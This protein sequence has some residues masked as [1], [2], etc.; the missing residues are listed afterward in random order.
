[1]EKINFEDLP[2]TDTPINSTNLNLLQTNVENSINDIIEDK[3]LT[4]NGYQKI[5]DLI[6]QWGNYQIDVTATQV[7]KIITFPKSFSS[8]FTAIAV[9]TDPGSGSNTFTGGVG[10]KDITNSNM[11]ITVKSTSNYAENRVISVRWIAI[12]I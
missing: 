9:F 7:D 12:G 10:V 6:I 11:Q 2:S 8:C 4:E 3:S 5:G 1:M